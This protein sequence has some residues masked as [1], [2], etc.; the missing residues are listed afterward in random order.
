MKDQ[1]E[2]KKTLGALPVNNSHFTITQTS[3]LLD[4]V[5]WSLVMTASRVL[6]EKPSLEVAKR[7]G[8]ACSYTDTV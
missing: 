3:V 6:K 2:C 7:G 4:A 8:L 5:G 1:E